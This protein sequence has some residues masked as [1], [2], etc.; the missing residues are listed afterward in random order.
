MAIFLRITRGQ[1]ADFIGTNHPLKFTLL[2]SPSYFHPPISPSYF[3]PPVFTYLF[4]PTFFHP[5]VGEKK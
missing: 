3:Y 5:K 2:F 4:S 1:T